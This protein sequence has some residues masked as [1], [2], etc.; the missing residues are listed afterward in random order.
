[1]SAQL[2]NDNATAP[3][4]PRLPFVLRLRSLKASR[5]THARILREYAKGTIDTETYRAVVWGLNNYLAYL[6]AEQA[7]EL[8]RRV[9]ALEERLR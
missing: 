8:E 3:E 6:K 5:Q 2:Q 1:M 7:E 4:G 9:I